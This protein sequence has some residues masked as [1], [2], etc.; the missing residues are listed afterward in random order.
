MNRIRLCLDTNILHQEGLSSQRMQIL[1]KLIDD[2]KVL[3]TIPEIVVREYASKL[4]E[5]AEEDIQKID[6]SVKNLQKRGLL[7]SFTSAYEGACTSLIRR[8]MN[9]IEDKLNRWL[10]VYSVDVFS[11]GNTSVPSLFESYFSGTGAF[12]AKKRRDDIPDALIYDGISQ[13]S[14]DGELCVAVKDTYLKSKFEA[15]ANV[16]CYENL[17]EFLSRE[18]IKSA[19]AEID[20]KD[21]KIG[22]LIRYMEAYEFS[23]IMEEYFSV[24]EISGIDQTYYD[25]SVTL[26]HDLRNLMCDDLEA[27]AIDPH[28]DKRIAISNALYLGHSR[29]SASA[30]IKSK[31]NLSFTCD[32]EDF[33]DLPRRV[34]KNLTH[35]STSDEQVIVKGIF[36]A[37]YEAVIELDGIN[38]VDQDINFIKNSLDNLCGSNSPYSVSL[39]I[40]K[41]VLDD[42]N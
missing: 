35:I 31:V 19:L 4:I 29:F 20:N 11:M 21:S 13:L 33:E 5:Y 41:V 9:S 14:K 25:S 6:K 22:E 10:A 30:E 28:K 12:K 27:R 38:F 15:L 1:K 34:R 18:D 36:D 23:L 42:Q 8:D 32:K 3:L 40:E 2:S 26:P 7:E 39:S 17:D 24:F 16:K 37:K